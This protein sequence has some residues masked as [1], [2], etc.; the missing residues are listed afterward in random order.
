MSLRDLLERL[1]IPILQAPLVGA[2][3]AALAIAVSRAGGLG[4]LAAG[5]L[6]P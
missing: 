6:A 5:A 3:D 1:P 2:S 4:G